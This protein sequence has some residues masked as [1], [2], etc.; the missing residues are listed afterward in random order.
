[1]FFCQPFHT[2]LLLFLGASLILAAAPETR[3][4]D[5]NSCPVLACGNPGIAG[6]PG[7]DGRDGAKGEKGDTGLQVKGQPGFPGK[8]GP[9]GPKGNTGAPGQK[10]QKGEMSAVDT[11]QRQVAALEKTVQT[12]QAEVRK[13]QKIFA[14]LG[15]TTVGGKTFVFT[16]QTHNFASG[17]ALCSNAG[18]AL[19]VAMNV[20]ENTALAAMAK[21][22]GKQIYLGMSD[23]Q[24]EGQFVYLNGQAV[25]Y[26]NW[27]RSEPNNLNNED[28]VVLIPDTLWN[29]ISCDH[30]T[31]IVCEL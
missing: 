6:L 26:T 3:S 30:Q 22:N 10:G 13:S 4:S 5:P 18:G 1:M 12:L 31:H 19:A 8:A 21:R 2:L 9:A 14:M 11:V 29:D 15:A 7:R 17:K 16:G 24:T 27:K 23:L 28:C 25:R 20:A